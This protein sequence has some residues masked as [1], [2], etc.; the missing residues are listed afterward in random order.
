MFVRRADKEL[1][2]SV[3]STVIVLGVQVTGPIQSTFDLKCNGCRQVMELAPAGDK[4][5]QM[6]D[7]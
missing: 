2:D 1:C 4:G 5:L 6:V 7:S 3:A